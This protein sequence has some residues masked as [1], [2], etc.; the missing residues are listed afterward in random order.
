VE[1]VGLAFRALMRR[2]WRSWLTIALLVSVVGGLVLAGAAAGRRTESAFPRLVAAHGFD[3]FVYAGQLEPKLAELPGVASATEMVGPDNGQPTCACTHPINPTDLGVLVPSPNGRSPYKLVSGRL[4]NQSDPDEV[5]AS[6]SLQQDDGVHIGSV[7]HVPFYALSQTAAYNSTP[8]ALLKPTGPTIA[9]RVVGIEAS[10]NEF[11]SGGTPSY[12]LYGT[13]AFARTVVPRTAHGYAY[14]VRLR[15]GVAGLPR[16]DAEMSA[17]G[18]AGV[19]F[20]QNEQQQATSI[21]SSI[22]PQAVGWWILAALAALVGLAVVGQGLA[23][24]S[25]VESEDFPTMAAIGADRRQ[26][27]ALGM[28]R[29]LVVALAGAAGAVIVATAMSPIAPLGEARIAESSTGIAFDG[30]VLVLGALGTMV[31]VL[32]LGIVPAL[33]AANALRR[34]DRSVT[35]RPSTVMR[36]LAATGAPPSAVIGV[37]NAVE[38]RSGGSP[39]P[40]G[41]AFLGTLLAVIALCG[42]A[43]FGASLSH[44]TATPRLYGDTFQLNFNDQ[45]GGGPYPSL[46]KSLEQNKAVTGITE[47]IGITEITV[48]KVLVGGIAGTAI[49][50]QLLLSTVSGHLPRANNQI[51]LGAT[52][53]RQAGAHVG[54]LVSVTVSSPSGRKRTVPFRVVSEIAFPVLAGAVS[55]GTGAAFTTSG[56]EAATCPSGPGQSA[57]RQAVVGTSDGGV[58]AS[59][60]SGPR[61]QAAINQILNANR[62]ITTLA[63]TPTSLINFGE[64]VNFPLIFGAV[65]AVFGAA[66]LLHLLV[67]SVARRRRE[68]GLLKVVGFVNGQVV[69]AVAWQASTLALG[70]V[71]IGLPLGVVVGRA[72]WLAF[73]GTLGVVPVSVVPIWLLV[74][75]AGGVIVVA[76]L[77]A[78][79]PA[80]VATRSKPGELLRAS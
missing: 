44:L 5:L 8:D 11:P 63:I 49:R 59:V 17:L 52:T 30:P 34:D 55:L 78:I 72:V 74:A 26:L 57:C 76:N 14:F 69:S 64:A 73:A 80:L 35:A 37:R 19:E 75:L 43:V 77:I 39:I 15:N 10:E 22:H 21:E 13:A 79:A 41:S 7:I 58:L 25:L 50:G 31:V 28:A 18:S 32:G 33:R 54:S 12:T 27:F 53:M 70:G 65:L 45:F 51:G 9:F 47:G 23:R 2:R 1:A 29:N 40:V 6:F 3:A 60:V 36:Y 68:V 71:I 46:L 38:R 61:G 16:F 42:T 67:V 20:T 62:S 56:Y 66:T 48:N 24:Q 4:A